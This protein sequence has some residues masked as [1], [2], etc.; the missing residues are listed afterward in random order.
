MVV[1]QTIARE[2]C[3]NQAGVAWPFGCAVVEGGCDGL[4]GGIVCCWLGSC[5]GG[6]GGLIGG[7]RRRGAVGRHVDQ[8]VVGVKLVLI[9]GQS[10]R[11]R[12]T[13]S[14]VLG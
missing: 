8:Y 10:W 9:C 2:N 12:W 1:G 14:E 4:A 3:V 11:C 5:C 7:R 13:R 6:G